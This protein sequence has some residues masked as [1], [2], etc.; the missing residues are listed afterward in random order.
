MNDTKIEVITDP[1]EIKKIQPELN[2]IKEAAL[3][4]IKFELSETEIKNFNKFKEKHGIGICDAFPDFSGAC[5]SFIFMPTG[6]GMNTWVECS[7][8]AKEYITDLSNI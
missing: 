7:C 5:F 4:P 1:E 2:K 6:L 3:F 8:G